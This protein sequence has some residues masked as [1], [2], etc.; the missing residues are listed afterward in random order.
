MNRVL[1]VGVLIFGAGRPLFHAG[2]QRRA[3]MYSNASPRRVRDRPDDFLGT[4][5]G[6]PTGWDV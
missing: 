4:Q 3:A 5:I 6:G 1:A 2:R